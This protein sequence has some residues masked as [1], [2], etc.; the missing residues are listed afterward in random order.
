MPAPLMSAPAC[1]RHP[2]GGGSAPAERRPPVHHFQRSNLQASSAELSIRERAMQAAAR[3]QGKQLQRTVR[4]IR[5]LV[6]KH[7]RAGGWYLPGMAAKTAHQS[8]RYASSRSSRTFDT[9]L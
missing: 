8:E 1:C 2:G 6:A 7:K 4:A 3:Q 9:G 5:S